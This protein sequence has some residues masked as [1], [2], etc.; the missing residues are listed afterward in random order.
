MTNGHDILK[1]RAQG[2]TYAEISER[3]EIPVGTLRVKAMRAK[4]AGAILPVKTKPAKPAKTSEPKQDKPK[5]TPKNK[6]A[7]QPFQIAQGWRRFWL[8]GLLLIPTAVSIHNVYGFTTELCQSE[9][10]AVLFTAMLSVLPA[11]L[12]G[13]GVR[14]IATY[15]LIVLVV[16]FEGLCNAAQVYSWQFSVTGAPVRFLKSVTDFFESGSY[17]TAVTLSYVTAIILAGA[18]FSIIYE[19]SKSKK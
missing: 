2:L 18:T 17:E 9:I 12:I 11:G 10:T 15:F 19:L 8:F 6:P 14:N 4:D 5:D 3:T 13:L 16:L 7:K 1:M